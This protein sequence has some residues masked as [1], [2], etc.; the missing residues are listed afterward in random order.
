MPGDLGERLASLEQ[1]V[2]DLERRVSTLSHE[3]ELLESKERKTQ[4]A[5]QLI[6]DEQK[7]NALD[8]SHRQRRIE[9]RVEVLTGVVAFAALAASLVQAVL[10]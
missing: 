8:I 2:R 6:L 4:W 10:H 7:K 5:V 3:H 1:V 9:I